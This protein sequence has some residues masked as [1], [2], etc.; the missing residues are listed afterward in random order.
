MRG[1]NIIAFSK[2]WESDW[3]SNHHVLTSLAR[4]NR[5]L[6]VNSIGMRSP[7]ISSGRDWSTAA[8][9][10]WRCL[11]GTRKVRDNLYVFTPIVW[12]FSR[13]AALRR[14]SMKSVLWQLRRLKRRLRMTD[15]QL[16]TF[17]PTAG[18][19][20]G[21]LD[22]K[23]AVYYCTDNWRLFQYLRGAAIENE[24]ERLLRK[25][26]VVFCTSDALC[27]EK[28][29]DNPHTFLISH[30]VDRRFLDSRDLP[31]PMDLRSIPR[32]VIGFFGWLRDTI[33]PE[34]LMAVSCSFPN[35]SI[36]LI[37]RVSGDFAL[38]RR[39]P[40]IHFLG[41]KDYRELPSYGRFF[42]V[43]IIPYRM[44]PELMAA[45]NPIKL[46]EYFALG[47]PVVTTPVGD[48]EAYRDVCWVAETRDDFIRAVAEALGPEGRRRAE[49]A[50]QRAAAETWDRKIQEISAILDRMIP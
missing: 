8:R 16:W 43:G 22:E 26:S 3:T 6:W 7:D 39:Q 2:E 50:R 34:L 12:P 47:L 10:V 1:K 5:V 35:A 41:Q 28:K 31:E 4:T 30:G 49:H 18:E 25:V 42:S 32:P 45:T 29:K 15:T 24:E 19:F 11:R 46:K 27:H 23:I 40:N 14:M 13:P 38:L 44:T 9:K 48:I 21:R 36:V 33:D 20:I 17:L 37:G